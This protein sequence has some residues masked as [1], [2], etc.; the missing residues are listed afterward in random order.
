MAKIRVLIIGA[1]SAI[2]QA[3]ARIYAERQASLYLLA[4]N[5]DRL[6]RVRQDLEARFNASVNQ[7]TLDFGNLSAFAKSITNAV[8]TIG[9]LD[10]A[11]LAHGSLPDQ[12]AAAADPDLVTRALHD[13]FITHAHFTLYLAHYFRKQKRGTIAVISSVSG[14]RGRKKNYVYGTAK[15]AM[16]TWLEGLRAE[17]HSSGVHVLTIKPGF[18]DTP[19]TAHLPKGPLFSSPETIARGIVRAI[20]KKRD[21]VYLPWFWRPIMAVIR[22]IPEPIFKRLSI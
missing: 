9:G 21:T 5:E 6:Q 7:A 2:A 8:N 3:V 18:V 20:D 17:L 12:Q 13:N 15:A 4:R 10:I 16:A 19:M 22:T 11:I 1:T 14:D